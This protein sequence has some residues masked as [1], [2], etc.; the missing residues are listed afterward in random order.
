MLTRSNIQ[1]EIVNTNM[2]LKKYHQFRMAIT[3]LTAFIF[4]QSLVLK[5]FFIPV[6]VV[7]LSSL[8][9]MYLR[10]QVKEVLADE[11]DYQIGGQ[12]AAITIQIY[13]WTAAIIMF[14]LYALRDLNPTYE[15]VAITLAYSTCL[16]MLCYSFIFKFYN[17]FNFSKKKA[18]LYFFT[19][20]VVA[21]IIVF[22]LR[23]FSG[24][25]NWLCQNGQWVKHGQP[26]FPAPTTICK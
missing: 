21:V 26:S 25:D 10:R 15:P 9:L 23:L 5:N 7:L 2:T 24:E 22:T 16:L 20:L 11:R 17:R 6:I 3:I 4:S 1:L 18:T 8:I 12:S 19:A 14:V 13:S